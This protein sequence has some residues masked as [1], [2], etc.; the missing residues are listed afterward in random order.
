M[1]GIWNFQ[2][3]LCHHRHHIASSPPFLWCDGLQRKALR[4]VYATIEY[5]AIRILNLFFL[6][7][8]K[9]YFTLF[10]TKILCF[11]CFYANIITF[12]LY[13]SKFNLFNASQIS[14]KLSK[15]G[16]KWHIAT[17]SELLAQSVICWIRDQRCA[18]RHR[19]GPGKCPLFCISIVN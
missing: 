14:F 7:F 12:I 8:V 1:S 15:F 13:L 11:L 6:P 19:F 4:N 16:S 2:H 3:R 10:E 18:E 9:H 5:G 17:Q